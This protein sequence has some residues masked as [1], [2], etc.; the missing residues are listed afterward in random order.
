ML[1]T[2]LFQLLLTEVAVID[3]ATLQAGSERYHLAGID[4]PGL[5]PH[6]HCSLEAQRGEKVAARMKALV[7]GATKVEAVPVGKPKNG[8]TW[9]TDKYGRRL[10]S[11]MIDG[12]DAG[13]ILIDEGLAEVWRPSHLRDWCLP[14]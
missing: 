6:A 13:Q 7:A 4:V 11:V 10:V 1:Y 12:R 3:G 2:L 14:W 5:A 8:V 9:S